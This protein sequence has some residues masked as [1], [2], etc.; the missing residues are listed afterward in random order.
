M[1]TKTD[2]QPT[3]EKE[4]RKLLLESNSKADALSAQDELY[5]LGLN[6]LMLARL[7]IQLEEELGVDPFIEAEA[8]ADVRSV[9]DLVS[10]YKRTLDAEE[11]E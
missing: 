2:V 1:L 9:G 11:G 6:S 8:I 5:D 3:V 7:I 4:I 10:A